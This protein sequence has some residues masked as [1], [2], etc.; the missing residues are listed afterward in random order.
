MAELM[1]NARNAYCPDGSHLCMWD[2]QAVY[3]EQLLGFLRTV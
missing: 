1:P 2:D 3:F